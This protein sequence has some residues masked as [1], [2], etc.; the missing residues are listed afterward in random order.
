MN[1]VPF[2]R[3]F[4][5]TADDNLCKLIFQLWTPMAKARGFRAAILMIA[6]FNGRLHQ[7]AMSTAKGFR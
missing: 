6:V 3:G 2:L 7:G 5:V 1:D 4:P